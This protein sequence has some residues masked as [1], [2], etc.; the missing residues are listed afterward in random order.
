[1]VESIYLIE[2]NHLAIKDNRY[3]EV[4]ILDSEWWELKKQI[5]FRLLKCMHG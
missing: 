5:T 1:M 3:L 4:R 2:K